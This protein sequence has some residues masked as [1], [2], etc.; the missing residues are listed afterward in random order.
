VKGRIGG[1]A[2]ERADLPIRALH[3]GL[4]AVGARHRA[5]RDAREQ[6]EDLGQPEA[7]LCLWPAVGRV[8]QALQRPLG[9]ALAPG[10]WTG[11]VGR[12]VLRS[13]VQARERQVRAGLGLD[14]DREHTWVAVH[15][16]DE[17]LTAQV[18]RD[19]ELPAGQVDLAGLRV[20]LEAALL[21]EG[22]VEPASARRGVVLIS[23]WWWSW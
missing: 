12:E 16:E 20:R 19:G 1:L 3:D 13:D 2:R 14:D 8:V 17:P 21:A 18:L 15:P 11:V 5:L 4:L 9:P 6:R 7:R 10:S 22:V 23:R